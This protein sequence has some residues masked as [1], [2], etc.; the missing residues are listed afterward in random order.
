MRGKKKA[1]I[2]LISLKRHL[3]LA[4]SSRSSGQN[5]SRRHGSLRDDLGGGVG[6]GL[7]DGRGTKVAPIPTK[8]SSVCLDLVGATI[9]LDLAHCP[10]AKAPRPLRDVLDVD[11]LTDLQR[12]ERPALG[13]LHHLVSVVTPGRLES[14]SVKRV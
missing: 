7:G 3:L 10:S 1:G 6:R 12:F 4:D 2:F 13:G 9:G 11:S 5:G 8:D 14:V